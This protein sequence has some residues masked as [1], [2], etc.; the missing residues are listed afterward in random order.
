M[1]SLRIKAL[2]M[3]AM[4]ACTLAVGSLPGQAGAAEW[5]L[6][7]IEPPPLVG[8]EGCTPTEAKPCRTPVG[9]G[10]IGDVEFAAAN[11]GLL[12]TAGNGSTV[13]SGVWEYNG[14]GW[15]ELAS[16]CG[17]TDGRIAWAAPATTG[18]ASAGTAEEFWTVSN[19]RPGQAANPNGV[20]P[21]IE[22]DTLCHF[23]VNPA[24]DKLEIVTSYAS[25]GFEANSYQPMDA[26]ACL[27]A[28][29]CW[30]AGAPLPAPQLG[31]FHLHWNGSSV[32]PEANT[33][34]KEVG[35][36]SVFEGKLYEGVGLLEEIEG[37]RPQE[38]LHP[39]VLQEIS[40]EESADVF[41]PQHPEREGNPEYLLPEYAPGSRPRALSPLQ[42]S[43]D[44]GSLWAA[45]GPVEVPPAGSNLGELTVLHEAGG[46]WSQVLGPAETGPENNPRPSG[47]IKAD[48]P[49][50]QDEVVNSVAAEPGT[51]SVWLALDTQLDV[52]SEHP[53]PTELA[54]VVHLEADGQLTEQQL[55]S[56]AERE[57]G[58]GPKGAAYRITCPAQ[59]DCWL[60]TTQGWL[61]HLSE[62]ASLP[63]DGDPAFNGP[64][65]T[66]RPPD[67]GIP[68]QQGDA[69]PPDDSGL[70]E[71]P[72][73]SSG[74]VLTK[75]APVDTFA[76]VTLPLLSNVHTR[77][78]HGT[79]LELSFHLAV[80]ARIRLIAKRKSKVVASTST[81]TFKAG[82]RSLQLLLNIH[83]WPT[84]L[85]LQTHA[86]APLPTAST[87]GA[88]VETVSTSLAFPKALGL[89]GWGPSL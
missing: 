68:Q 88:G 61:F 65:I 25:L 19:G 81:R 72:P 42:L 75:A 11:R 27:S 35:S 30:F 5:H 53:S 66:Y 15:H 47:S 71:S 64:P 28:T 22:D 79:T 20:L 3:L 39:P 34:V 74:S 78:I 56:P 29:D 83:R 52:A 45:A 86:L 48:P 63:V 84:K 89:T 46:I 6:Q 7:P 49:S 12:I 8:E 73:A 36:L 16:K 76:T 13:Q 87:R 58:V 9:L 24:T 57:E 4:L 14:A 2:L 31:A 60:A 41:E 50:L 17:A 77:L 1:R 69:P 85:E 67:E 26:A 10:R 40:A 43:S 54:T 80:K 33:R 18:L 70:E 37:E 38:I 55:P 44:E 32:E 82:K 51:A 62:G 21:P 23:A 59:N